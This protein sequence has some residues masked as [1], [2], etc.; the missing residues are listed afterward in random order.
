MNEWQKSQWSGP[1]C[2]AMSQV[3]P[4]RYL[5]NLH[6]PPEWQVNIISSNEEA[7]AQRGQVTCSKLHSWRVA[8]LGSDPRSVWA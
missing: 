2:P 7:K 1:Q 6:N 5:L 4:L 8:E 3:L